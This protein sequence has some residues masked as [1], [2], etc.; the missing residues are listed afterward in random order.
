MAKTGELLII[1]IIWGRTKRAENITYR[2]DFS[3]GNLFPVRQ[4]IPLLEFMV[5]EIISDW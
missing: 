5:S 2:K 4:Y 1:L 3:W